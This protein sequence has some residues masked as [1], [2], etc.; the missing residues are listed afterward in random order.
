ML[1]LVLLQMAFLKCIKFAVLYPYSSL[2]C[3]RVSVHE[4]E[5][6]ALATSCHHLEGPLYEPFNPLIAA[7]PFI[8]FIYYIYI[9]HSHHAT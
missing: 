1:E 7:T 6:R 3:V 5:V 2:L 4:G 9:P 8:I